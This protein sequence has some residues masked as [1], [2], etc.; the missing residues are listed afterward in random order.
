MGDGQV[1]CEHVKCKARKDRGGGG[2]NG[3]RTVK[4]DKPQDQDPANDAERQQNVFKHVR[5]HS[6]QAN[7]HPPMPDVLPSMTLAA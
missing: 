2:L 5:R 7:V 4:N 3:N 6:R 1:C